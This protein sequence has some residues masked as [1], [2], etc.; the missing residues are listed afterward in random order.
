MHLLGV[1]GEAWHVLESR[2]GWILCFP[3]TLRERFVL[4]AGCD[5]PI[6]EVQNNTPQS[7]SKCWTHASWTSP[8]PL[9]TCTGS[10]SAASP[11]T[12]LVPEQSSWGCCSKR[13]TNPYNLTGVYLFPSVPAFPGNNKPG[14][15]WWEPEFPPPPCIY[16]I[17]SKKLSMSL[18]SQPHLTHA[19]LK[20]GHWHCFNEHS[21]ALPF[22]LGTIEAKNLCNLASSGLLSKSKLFFPS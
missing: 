15:G 3:Q 19:H 6:S 5:H 21:Q 4:G 16:S 7:H 22:P 10:S 1:R 12:Y 20:Q 2:L 8:F 18:L 13:H 11:G 9:L 17:P 14:K